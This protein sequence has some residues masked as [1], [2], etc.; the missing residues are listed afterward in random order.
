MT[1]HQVYAD[2]NTDA[3]DDYKMYHKLEKYKQ[4]ES[5]SLGYASL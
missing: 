1:N 2:Q 4:I 5:S 3:R